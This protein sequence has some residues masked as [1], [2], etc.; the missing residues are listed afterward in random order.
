MKA[1]TRPLTWD[2]PVASRLKEGA[3]DGQGNESLLITLT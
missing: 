3:K 2:D 1:E